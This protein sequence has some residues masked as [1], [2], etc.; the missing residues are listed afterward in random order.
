[1]AFFLR[2]RHVSV[3]VVG[4]LV[5]DRQRTMTPERHMSSRWHGCQGL[6]PQPFPVDLGHLADLLG[7]SPRI[8]PKSPH[9]AHNGDL[10]P[11]DKD[12]DGAL[13]RGCNASRA[14]SEEQGTQGEARLQGEAERGR[15]GR[16]EA[17]ARGGGEDDLREQEGSIG[18]L[19]PRHRRQQHDTRRSTPYSAAAPAKPA[20]EAIPAAAAS[21]AR[22]CSTAHATATTS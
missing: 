3:F 8:A 5:G 4:N 6:L 7:I 20:P 19:R 10:S 14:L 17:E 21:A 13:R 16:L 2:V 18:G 15:S 9:I 22:R 11:R 1:M 12:T